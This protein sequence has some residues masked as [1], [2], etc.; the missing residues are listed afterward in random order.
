MDRL[1]S[2]WELI[3]EELDEW[4]GIAYTDRRPGD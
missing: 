1:R 3:P 4:D 2:V